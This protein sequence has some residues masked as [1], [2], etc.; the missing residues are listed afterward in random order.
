M[1]SFMLFP[2]PMSWMY[3]AGGLVVAIALYSLQRTGKKPALEMAGATPGKQSAGKRAAQGA[4]GGPE[5]AP[6]LGGG[7]GAG[8][9]G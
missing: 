1:L 4:E 7:Q 3:T 9:S 5:V 2:K 8:P 6:L